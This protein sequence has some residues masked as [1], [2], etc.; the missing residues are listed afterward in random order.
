LIGWVKDDAAFIAEQ[1]KTFYDRRKPT[2]IRES[3]GEA[4]RA[5]AGAGTRED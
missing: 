4:Q 5:G 2:V 1:I 3:G